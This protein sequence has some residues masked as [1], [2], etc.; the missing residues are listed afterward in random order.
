MEL[1]NPEC[2]LEL[3]HEDLN[4]NESGRFLGFSVAPLRLIQKTHSFTDLKPVK[5]GIDFLM[6]ILG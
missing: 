3:R 2:S 1:L 6:D 5:S 4:G